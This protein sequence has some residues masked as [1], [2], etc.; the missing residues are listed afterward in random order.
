M[1]PEQMADKYA[2]WNMF[3]CVH[4]TIVGRAWLA[5]F[6]AAQ[7]PRK[8]TE[9]ELPVL[10]APSTFAP[11]ANRHFVANVYAYTENQMREYARQV[12]SLMTAPADRDAILKQV[13]KVCEKRAEDRFAEHGYTEHD[14]NAGYY[15]G[16]QKEWRQVLPHAPDGLEYSCK[17]CRV[18]HNREQRG[19]KN[20][21]AVLDAYRER[22]RQRT[23]EQH[24][25]ARASRVIDGPKRWRERNSEK[26]EA[27]RLLK[28]AIARGHIDRQPCFICGANAHG[29]HPDY[30]RP[31]EVT[32][33]CPLHHAQAHQLARR[34]AK[35][36]QQS[37]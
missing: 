7:S 22:N 26:H 25:A 8:L 2:D 12:A 28:L 36:R 21:L 34:I 17:T 19:S 37:Q 30:S 29:H 13:A 3:P 15:A 11:A 18:A 10:P 20:G 5:G 24:R 27:Q 32:W 14:T 31:L 4:P 16:S 1:T 33:L 6:R 9:E 35:Q 23:T